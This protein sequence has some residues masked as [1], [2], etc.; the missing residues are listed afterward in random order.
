VKLFL[1]LCAVVACLMHASEH[2]S[3]ATWV[4]DVSN[5]NAMVAAGDFTTVSMIDSGLVTF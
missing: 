5:A 4:E 3:F 1:R 2:G